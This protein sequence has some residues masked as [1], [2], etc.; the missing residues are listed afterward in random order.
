MKLFKV[1]IFKLS[2]IIVALI[3]G[4]LYLCHMSTNLVVSVL[5]ISGI[6]LFIDTKVNKENIYEANLKYMTEKNSKNKKGEK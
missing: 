4:A 3:A 5:A 2:A 1:Y 6:I